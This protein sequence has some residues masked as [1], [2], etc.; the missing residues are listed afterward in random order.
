M[1]L[2]I[3]RRSRPLPALIA[4]LVMLATA[5]PRACAQPPSPARSAE[6]SDDRAERLAE[7]KQIVRPLKIVAIDDRGKETPAATTE[8]PAHRWTDPT[9]DFSGGAL[10]IWRVSGRPVAVVSA[11]LYESWSLEFVSVTP[12][13]VRADDESVSWKPRA[14][15]VEFREIPEAPAVAATEA[16]RSRQMRDLA[17]RFAAR[18]HWIGGNGQHYAL[19]L[20]PHPIDR[21]SDESSGV[22]DGAIFVHANGTN[23]EILLLIEALR[24]GDGKARWSFAAAPLSRAEVRL[25]LGQKDVWTSP[26]KDNTQA[27]DRGNPYYVQFFPAR[28]GSPG[29][30]RPPLSPVPK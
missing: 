17:K 10:W 12:D 29:R 7:M 5:V 24:E 14:G 27:Y 22:V 30:S 21:Y 26:D 23:P 13:L 28:R 8:E 2:D 20:L 1:S 16:G 18:E 19:R 4:L 6:E 25:K 15:G 3:S 9:R 11:E